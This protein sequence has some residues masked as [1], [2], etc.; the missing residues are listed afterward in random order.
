MLQT[1]RAWG[2]SAMLAVPIALAALPASAESR[3]VV[4]IGGTATVAFAA[5]GSRYAAWQESGSAAIVV[6]DART[7]RKRPLTVPSGCLLASDESEFSEEVV[8]RA[9]SGRFL[10]DCGSAQAALDVE[11]GSLQ[12][13]PALPNRYQWEE[14]G[15]RYAAGPTGECAYNQCVAVVDLAT[16]RVSVRHESAIPDLDR[17]GAPSTQVCPALRRRVATALVASSPAPYA[18]AGGL[19]VHAAKRSGYIE[20]DRCKRAPTLIP[21]RGEPRDFD[22]RDGLLTWDTGYGSS[23]APNEESAHSSILGAYQLA[24]GSHR[25]WALPRLAVAEEPPGPRTI[26]YSEHAGRTVFWVATRSVILGKAGNAPGDS[27]VYSARF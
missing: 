2:A 25:T 14:V 8:A 24:T 4:R 20:I 21:G 26:G 22:L 3:A 15:S 19:F 5:D 27:S 10:L 16:K 13:L 23:V 17:P 1:L 9:R 6:F 11:N 18:Y 12:S 7:S